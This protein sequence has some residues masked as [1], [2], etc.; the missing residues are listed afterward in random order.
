MGTAQLKNT[1]VRLLACSFDEDGSTDSD[2]RF[3]LDE[4]NVKY[5]ST[6]PGVFPDRPLTDRTFA[7]TLIGELLPPFPPGDWNSGH[8]AKDPATAEVYFA[9]LEAIELPKVETVWHPTQLNEVDF[10]EQDDLNQRVRICTSPAINNGKPV[11]VKMAVWPWEI[12]HMRT[13]TAIY[14]SLHESGSRAGPKFLGHLLEGDGGRVIGIVIEYAGNMRRAAG[15]EDLTACKRALARLHALSIKLGDP[16]H[17]NFLVPKGDGA[18]GKE[19][20]L[21]DF[22]F[23]KQNCSK[24]ELEEE[25]ELLQRK[26]EEGDQT[27]TYFEAEEGTSVG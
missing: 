18:E 21:I 10:T 14:R 2:Y 20:I 15:L 13:E 4:K 23:A 12:D 22:E 1:N 9:R 26:L 19:V 27:A 11:I 6:A 3:L 7:P 17:G 8:V 24:A 5:V 25:M 16:D